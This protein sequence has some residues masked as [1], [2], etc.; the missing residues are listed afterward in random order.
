MTAIKGEW[1]KNNLLGAQKGE[2]PVS[3]CFS[4]SEVIDS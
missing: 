1:E 3:G 4:I 2:F